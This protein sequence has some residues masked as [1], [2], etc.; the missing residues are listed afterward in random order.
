MKTLTALAMVLMLGSAAEAKI[1]PSDRAAAT[2]SANTDEAV[3][4][5]G[6]IGAMLEADYFRA[7]STRAAAGGECRLRLYFS[8]RPVQF[9]RA[10][11]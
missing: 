6:P 8:D 11:Y 3:M 4:Y 1:T 2:P 10:C 7:P 9:A 5:A